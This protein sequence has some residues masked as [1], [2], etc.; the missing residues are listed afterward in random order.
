MKLHISNLLGSKDADLR[1]GKFTVF[2]GLNN[3]GK[4]FTCK[5][6]YAI[7]QSLYSNPIE[8][9]YL[10]KINWLLGMIK[11]DKDSEFPEIYEITAEV[12]S[13]ARIVKAGLSRTFTSDKKDLTQHFESI[14][15]K[16]NKILLKFDIE[17][18]SIKS[19]DFQSHHSYEGRIYNLFTDLYFYLRKHNKFSIENIISKSLKSEITS[20]II[21]NFSEHKLS[22]LF[23]NGEKT[24]KVTLDEMLEFELGIGNE[25]IN[26][27]KV[28]TYNYRSFSN[29][30]YLDPKSIW[31][32][33]NPYVNEYVYDYYYSKAQGYFSSRN[34]HWNLIKDMTTPTKFK[35]NK[36]QVI[37]D[38]IIQVIGGRFVNHKYIIKF[39]N[40]EGELINLHQLSASTYQL[41]KLAF[42]IEHLLDSKS[43]L[44]IEDP[45]TH[46]HPELQILYMRCLFNLMQKGVNII[47][48]THGPQVMKY[49]EKYLKLHPEYESQIAINHFTKDGVKRKDKTKIEQ[50][51]EI[52]DE[53]GEPYYYLFSEFTKV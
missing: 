52:Q 20:Q 25:H 2:A 38:E 12:K 11:D 32:D 41:G 29:I 15:S 45:E 40:I 23:T 7:L 44:I 26:I 1:I 30:Y 13:I 42:V 18:L 19:K 21:G 4:N 49:I 9:L 43:L 36:F 16:A 3:T 14:K 47:I 51:N 22:T 37:A 50:V 48:T 31:F 6:L 33:A 53:L 34:Y 24:L 8:I 46:I 5:L 35:F 10:P 17:K 27:T 39:K 28:N